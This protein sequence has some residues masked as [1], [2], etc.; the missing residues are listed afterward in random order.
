MARKPPEY[1][2]DGDV[3]KI[4]IAGVGTIENPVIEEPD[5]DVI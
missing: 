1:L 3:V 5:T 2:K 4:Q